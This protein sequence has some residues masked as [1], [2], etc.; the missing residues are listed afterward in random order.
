MDSE[1]TETRT[2]GT[3]ATDVTELLDV[4][5]I[6]PGLD[7]ADLAAELVRRAGLLAARMRARGVRHAEKTSVSD[8][9][10]EADHAAEDLVVE[11]LR[12]A[13]PE[14]GLVGE[15]GG[16]RESTSGRTWVVDPVDGTYNFLSG[17]S[18]WCSALALRDEEGVVLG[19]VHHVTAGELWVGGP[20]TGTRVNGEPV[21]RIAD[22]PLDRGCLATYL[23][24]TRLAVPE[25]RDPFL[26]MAGGAATLRMLGSSSCDLA[27]VAAGRVEAWAQHSVH[28]WDWLPG[29]ALVLGVGGAT[30]L[31]EH[32]GTTWNLAG[33]PSA[34]ET[35]EG[36]LRSA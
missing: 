30:R 13:R 34:V 33:T 23:H 11:A 10:T 1:P 21:P 7:D 17:L 32:R 18:H 25:V 9:V 22:V 19:A 24:P 14:D 20:A 12:R 16:R 15:E 3:S 36:L 8:V 4:Q 28:E 26:A 35:L 29:Q 6:D 5:S 2:S 31:V 27:A